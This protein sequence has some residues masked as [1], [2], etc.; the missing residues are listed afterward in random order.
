MLVRWWPRGPKPMLLSVLFVAFAWLPVV[1]ALYASQSLI[2][3]I[4]GNFTLGRAPAHALF[5]G[6]FGSA[7]IAMVAR[8]TQGHS[9]RTLILPP[10][11]IFAF[12]S[13][14][15]VAILRFVAELMPDALFWQA[16]AAV[17]WLVALGPW[18]IGLNRIYLAPRADG[19]PG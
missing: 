7:L 2:F 1:F 17:G 16:L 8:V 12:I 4:T 14:Q 9:G 5:I 10:V 18:V 19:K 3:W 11:A 6:F 15:V 13:T